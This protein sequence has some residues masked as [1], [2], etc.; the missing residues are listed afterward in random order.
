MK[1]DSWKLYVDCA[2]NNKGCGVGFVLENPSKVRLEQS[3]CFAFKASNNQAKY[4]ALIADLSLVEDTRVTNL[5]CL[6]DSQLTVGQVNGSFQVKDPLLITYYQKVL[7]I[8]PRFKTIKLEHI[9]RNSNSRADILLK[10]ALGKGKGRYNSV[11][12]LTLIQPSIFIAKCMSAEPTE[13]EICAETKTEICAETKAKICTKLTEAKTCAEPA[14]VHVEKD[15]WRA[16]IREV[17]R[18][19]VGGEHVQDKALV[20]KVARYVI[21]GEDL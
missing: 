8:L 15:D 6:S 2:S 17:I 19:L 9:L 1:K 13:A 14:E 4:E 10:L 16:P 18:S 20:K 21:I 7:V 5:I 3:L 12:Q 11:I